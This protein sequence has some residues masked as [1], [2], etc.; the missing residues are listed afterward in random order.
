MKSLAKRRFIE[1][2]A[3]VLRNYTSTWDAGLLVE[4]LLNLI[5]VAIAL[6][7]LAV[8][9]VRL[10][11]HT[12]EH[13]TL[14]LTAWIALLTVI[15]VLFPVISVS[16]DFHPVVASSE[17][18]ARRILHMSTSLHQAKVAPSIVSLGSIL[19]LLTLTAAV[20]L[21]TWFTRATL[22]G[23]LAC[24]RGPQEGRSPPCF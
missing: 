12:P 14:H 15:I 18:P 20:A 21:P 5:W 23:I 19:L 13:G 1:Y 16:D 2:T 6:S 11:G 8:F 7:A 17:D 9:G 3:T 10:S 24:A 4:L 22:D